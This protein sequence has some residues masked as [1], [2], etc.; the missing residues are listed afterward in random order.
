MLFVHG[1][2]GTGKSMLLRQTARWTDPP[3]SRFVLLD[4]QEIEPTEAG[5]RSA[6]RGAI[7]G[8]PD[9]DGFAWLGTIADRVVICLDQYE[10][11]RLLDT[12]LRHEVVPALP[13]NVRLLIAGRE[14]P[15]TAWKRLPAGT[16][17]TR[18]LVRCRPPRARS[19]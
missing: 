14:E 13:A 17:D 6:L 10:V 12:W 8:T 5:F 7:G 18:R 16:F 9:E 3:A 4:C 15:H 11:L 1:M 2:S 19:C